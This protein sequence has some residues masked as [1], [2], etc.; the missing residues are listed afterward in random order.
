[1]FI[2]SL[3]ADLIRGMI[4]LHD[5]DIVYHGNLKPSNCLIDSRWVLQISDFGL[6]QFKGRKV[7]RKLLP[8]FKPNGRLLSAGEALFQRYGY[9][10]YQLLWKPPEFL[11]RQVNLRQSR[12]SLASVVTAI[13]IDSA[14]LRSS[15]TFSKKTTLGQ[16]QTFQQGHQNGSQKGDVYSF[17]IILYEIMGG[18]GP[19]GQPNLKPKDVAFIL[20]KIRNPT[21]FG[22]VRPP[23]EVRLHFTSIEGRGPPL[24][25]LIMFFYLYLVIK[26]QHRG[27]YSQLHSRVLAG[28]PV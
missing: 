19:W 7:T 5:S 16:Q 24:T 6:R 20:N 23:I 3:V 17:A 1:M 15:G 14:R 11:R 27:V 21:T 4:Y 9:T 18:Q 22:E 28:G 25:N 8:F 13:S 26:L 2:A 10:E 12:T